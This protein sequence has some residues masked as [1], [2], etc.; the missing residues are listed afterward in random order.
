[1]TSRPRGIT[2]FRLAA[3][4]L[5]LVA[6][7]PLACSDVTDIEL[8]EIRG[9]GVL[10]GQV[11]LDLDGSGEFTPSDDEPIGDVDVLVLTSGDDVVK[12]ASANAEGLFIIDSVPVGAY[13][14]SLE[15]NLLG[16]SL[17]V[18]G[19]EDT[20]SVGPT[21]TTRID[22]GATFPV[23]TIEEVLTAP[24][25]HQV[26]TSGIALND[27][28]NLD[29]SGQVHFEGVSAYL[30]ALNV[31]RSAI[32]TRD[33]VRLRGRVVTDNGRPALQDVT[34]FIL[35]KQAALVTPVEVSVAEAASAD[36][37]ALDAALVRIRKAEIT[38]T[39]TTVDGD[40]RFWAYV[41]ADSV[42]VLVREFLQADNEAFRPDTIQRLREL[43]GLLSPFD[44]GGG[45]IRW[46][47]LLREGDDAVLET[48][49][50]DLSVT[51]SLDTTEASLGDTVEVMVVVANDGPDDATVLE[52]RDTIPDQLTYV[53]STATQGTYDS[54]TGIWSIDELPAA[55]SDT[56]VIRME[57]TDGTPGTVTNV[58]ES[59]GLTF[60]V[61]TIAS[62]N[63]ATVTLT[64]S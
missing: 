52:V 49:S 26:F 27:R 55:G 14:L 41:D 48:K 9:A 34:P 46:R 47:I 40:F 54:D 61:E 56:L 53:S 60:E 33:S 23:L 20:I 5:A 63:E 36:G 24:A 21:D 64:I 1:M 15:A 37:G 18:V 51:A 39:S 22:V 29:T 62:N 50:A 6:L 4:G 2:R 43:T 19:I 8:L 38:D 58:A 28:V 13:R 35:V 59:L 3:A 10:F 16:D 32:V 17:E 57:V 25:G 12:R 44:E 7:A 42:E 11:F 45:S 30:R 31:E